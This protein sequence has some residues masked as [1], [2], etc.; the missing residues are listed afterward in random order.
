[1][2]ILSWKINTAALG[3]QAGQERASRKVDL[4]DEED[5]FCF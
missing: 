4:P 3:L 1:M 5:F 2:N